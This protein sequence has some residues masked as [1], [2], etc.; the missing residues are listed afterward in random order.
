MHEK[1]VLCSWNVT[2]CPHHTRLSFLLFIT[3]DGGKVKGQEKQILSIKT[4]GCLK[5][6]VC[7][8][9]LLATSEPAPAS[10]IPKQA[11]KSPAI[12]GT[13]NCFFN[14]WEPNLQQYNEKDRI[15]KAYEGK[16]YL[17]VSY[18]SFSTHPVINFPMT[19]LKLSQSQKIEQIPFKAVEVF[20]RSAATIISNK[21]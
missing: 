17:E 21:F 3:K 8:V 2:F 19:R 9:N 4:S 14:S 16:F 10:L 18:K 15:L 20:T 13:R 6:A 5:L 1:H 11:T 12:V 7:Q